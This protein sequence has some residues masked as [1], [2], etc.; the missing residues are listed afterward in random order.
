MYSQLSV[1]V[2]FSVGSE[3]GC[4]V[5]AVAGDSVDQSESDWF[6]IFIILQSESKNVQIRNEPNL[7]LAHIASMI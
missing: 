3:D 5:V 6:N 4:N 2:G 7:D 1:F